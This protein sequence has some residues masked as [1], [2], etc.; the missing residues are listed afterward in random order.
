MN[1]LIVPLFIFISL[2]QI[3][4]C[5]SAE[6]VEI[7][8]TITKC[9]FEKK[10]INENTKEKLEKYLNNYN[11]YYIQKVYEFMQEHINKVNLCINH[12]ELPQ[13][14][15]RNL[16]S[17]D[18]RLKQLNWYKYLDCIKTHSKKDSSLDKMIEL[19][20]DRDYYEA[21]LQEIK[22]LQDGNIVAIQC[23]NKKLENVNREPFQSGYGDRLL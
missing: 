12:L 20:N 6:E 1:S 17:F 22:L 23:E 11:P 19:I 7:F 5:N 9:L 3:Y 8:L 18:K 14:I 16:V 10:E 21:S 2:F 13:Y 15:R 4:Y